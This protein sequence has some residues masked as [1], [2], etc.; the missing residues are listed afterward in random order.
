MAMSARLPLRSSL[1]LVGLRVVNATSRALGFGQGTVAGGRVALRIDSQL[2]RHMSAHRRIVLVSGTNG[3]TTTTA[4]VV[5]ALGGGT[6]NATG[7]NMS[8][9]IVAALASN[10]Q[11]A[12][13]LEVDEAFLATV[14]EATQP[15]VI[16]LLNL[17]R[18]QLDRAAEVRVLAEKWRRMLHNSSATIVANCADPLVVYAAIAQMNSKVIWCDVG[19]S[20]TLDARSCP[21]CT[22]P[23]NPEG[24][25]HCECGFAKPV[26]DFVLGDRLAGGAESVSL[27][28]ALP[29]S[30]N[31]SNAAL[32]VVAASLL[33][34]PLE[35]AAQRV[36]AVREV[37]GRF[38]VRRREG[39]TFRLMLAKNPAGVA[40]LIDLVAGG[41]E[42]V[43]SINDLVADGTD[44]SWLYDA[45]FEQL[46]GSTVWCT[47]ERSLDLATRLDYAEVT[48]KVVAVENL[49]SLINSAEPIDVIANYT[50]F[51]AWLEATTP[52]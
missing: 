48:A 34:T 23:L 8:A 39:Q 20:W 45:P 17:S 25:W 28:V 47:G 16:V 29:G 21:Q 38:T 18:D 4:L 1:A 40:A 11:A 32:A 13:V 46:R 3:K 31:R 24:Q 22:E 10:H 43:V 33:D 5:A 9:G 2:I 50:A 26:A 49:A 41:R 42:V 6:T 19:S 35:T 44:P 7:S 27:E 14:A 51:A 36:S 52:C 37:A 30:F 12:T 15:E